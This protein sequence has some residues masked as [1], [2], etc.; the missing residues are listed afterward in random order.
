MPSALALQITLS[1]RVG[2][3]NEF[4]FSLSLKA[5][6]VLDKINFAEVYS[7]NLFSNYRALSL[8]GHLSFLEQDPENPTILEWL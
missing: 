4:L 6:A 7:S 2:N 1:C 5:Q 3:L 8:T